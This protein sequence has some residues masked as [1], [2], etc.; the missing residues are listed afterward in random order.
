[1]NYSHNI[2][3][4]RLKTAKETAE[5]QYPKHKQNKFYLYLSYTLM[6]GLVLLIFIGILYFYRHFNLGAP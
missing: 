3:E 6:T 1:M 5:K 2:D 4:S